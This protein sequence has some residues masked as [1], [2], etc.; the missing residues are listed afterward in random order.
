MCVRLRTSTS[1]SKVITEDWNGFEDYFQ[2]S[3][4]HVMV[5]DD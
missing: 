1:W 2:K 3:T 4:Y 5:R